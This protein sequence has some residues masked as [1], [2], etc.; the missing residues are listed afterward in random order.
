MAL[1][2]DAPGGAEALALL[3]AGPT[4]DVIICDIDMPEMDGVEFVT[5]VSESNLACAIVIASGLE[6]AMASARDV[7]LRVVADGCD[8]QADFDTLGCSEAQGRFVAEPM[9]A[10]D[11]VA[12]ARRGYR[13]DEPGR[14]L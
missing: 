2:T 6:S 8:S 7:G 1:V 10:A 9:P 5:R 14:P 13:P 11:T 3:H 4:P 12:W